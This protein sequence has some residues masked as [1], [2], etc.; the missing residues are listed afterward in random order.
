MKKGLLYFIAFLLL[1]S[2][3]LSA[4]PSTAQDQKMA[5]WREARFGM[6]IHWGPYALWGGEYHGHQQRVGGTEWIMNRCKIPVKEY[7]EMTRKF[8]PTD[9]NPEEWVRL[10]KETGMKY[11]VITTKH[12][13]GFAMF[14]S[15]A[16][17]YNM[18]DFTPYG[19]DVI[20]ALA[21][22]CRKYDMKLGFYYSQR[23]DWNNPGGATHRRPMSQG[24]AN[25]D[26]VTIDAYT[27][28]HQGSWDPA[29]QTRTF[30]EYVD[31]VAI[32]QVK[33]LL[34]NY[35]DIA[36]FFW[37]TPSG[38]TKADAKKFADGDENL[39]ALIDNIDAE[40]KGAQRGAVNGPSRHYDAVNGNSTDTY[41]ISFIANVLAEILVSGDG[42][43][44]LDLYVYDSN[45]N[46]IAS[47][48]DYTDD[49]YVCW[50][51]AWTGRFIVK[52]VNRGPVYNN[53]VILTN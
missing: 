31:N 8:N 16:S 52:I 48:T 45:G 13:D 42:D 38:M 6:F 2:V 35:G 15:K 25:P 44:D 11:I 19:K 5:W 22:A 33:E 18:V 51:P 20:D 36:V 4:Q 47:D 28:A 9:Y 50:V 39:L 21:K 32:P 29:Q 10:A 46:L 26:S 34:T 49:C 30:N 1:F 12:H 27:L 7:Q 53:Y 3:R 24:W 41:Q 43:T 14:K 23:Q 17:K 37:D 40:A